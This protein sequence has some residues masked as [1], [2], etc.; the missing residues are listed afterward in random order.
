LLDKHELKA[1]GWISE[2]LDNTDHDYVSPLLKNYLD[3]LKMRQDAGHSEN[4][5]F[6]E[7]MRKVIKM[8]MMTDVVNHQYEK[9]G[10]LKK[11]ADEQEKELESERKAAEH[12]RKVNILITK[13][14]EFKKEKAFKR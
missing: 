4:A 11:S 5:T 13:R 12:A 6:I 3:D 2:P 14:V 1:S 9:I 10:G 8:D 7:T